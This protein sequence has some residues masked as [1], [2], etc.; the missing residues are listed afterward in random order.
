MQLCTTWYQTVHNITFF[1][2][3]GC[4]T[5]KDASNTRLRGVVIKLLCSLTKFHEAHLDTFHLEYTCN[6]TLSPLVNIYTVQTV[7]I[8]LSGYSSL[9]QHAHKLSAQ[10]DTW[11]QEESNIN[12]NKQCKCIWKKKKKN[13]ESLPHN[14]VLSLITQL[15]Y[16]PIDATLFLDALNFCLL[17][18]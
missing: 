8:K 17:H 16:C 10:C 2:W 1:K 9:L 4:S 7:D 5:E 15:C 3:Q 13:R 14:T 11:E 12:K 6:N 18:S